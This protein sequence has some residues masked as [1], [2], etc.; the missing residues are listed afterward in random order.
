MNGLIQL[1]I[2]VLPNNH[3]IVNAINTLNNL[4][5]PLVVRTV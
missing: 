2:P 1:M 3:V 4:V 5:D